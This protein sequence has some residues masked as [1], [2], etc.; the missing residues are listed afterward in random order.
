MFTT[1]HVLAARQVIAP[2]LPPTP[3]IHSPALSALTG[4]VIYLKPECWQPTGS[5]KVR[6]ALT[7]LSSLSPEQ[8]DRGYVT[9]SAGN[10]GL[11]VAYA[12]QLLGLPPALIF[13]PETAPMA[14]VRRLAAFECRVRQEGA[15]YDSAHLI[16]DEYAHASGATYVSAYDDPLVIAGQAT[17]GLE[18]LEDIPDVDSILVPVGGGGLI[19]GIALVAKAMNP[20]VR[21]IGIQPDASPAAL[22]SLQD[23]KAHETYPAGPTICDGLAGGFGRVPFEL[24]RDLIDDI[25]I[26][27]EAS[28]RRSVAWLVD[29]EQMIV[30][31]SGAIS[32]APL[33]DGLLPSHG[34]KIV[35]VLTGRNLDTRLLVEIL[36]EPSL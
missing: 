27:S 30:E 31:G 4:G 11:G 15:D 13:V 5:F 21:V 35:P 12:G 32:I 18:I 24:A 6:G 23:G 1:A 17:A 34:Q 25:I 29:H 8:L 33:L 22:L 16:A 3:V 26:V 19:A 14:K 36:T 20:E 7:K 28:V 10:H 2:Y 9:A